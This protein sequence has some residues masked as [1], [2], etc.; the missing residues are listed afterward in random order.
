[1]LGSVN[2]FNAEVVADISRICAENGKVMLY[3]DADE[4]LET[5]TK[6]LKRMVE[7]NVANMFV[8][9]AEGSAAADFNLVRE[10][11]FE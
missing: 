3:G 11:A 1:M 2:R 4:N 9:A 7:N 8:Y 10:P 5:Q 6:I